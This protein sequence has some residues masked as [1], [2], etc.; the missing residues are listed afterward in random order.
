M[1]KRR[2]SGGMG[3]CIAGWVYGIKKA[4]MKGLRVRYIVLVRAVGRLN[5]HFERRF[6]FRNVFGA[7]VGV[8]FGGFNVLVAQ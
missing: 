3:I 4:P 1:D 6:D 2:G 5:R 8:N 7:Y